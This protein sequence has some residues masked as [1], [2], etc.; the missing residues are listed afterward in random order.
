MKKALII[1][2]DGT[3]LH[4][5]EDEQVDSIEKFSFLPGVIT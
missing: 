4:E 1:D 2:R 3:I 5:P